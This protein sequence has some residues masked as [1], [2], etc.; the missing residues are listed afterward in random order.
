MILSRDEPLRI[1]NLIFHLMRLKQTATMS[2]QPSF[3]QIWIHLNWHWYILWIC[4]LSKSEHYT[5]LLTF[6]WWS[7]LVIL[8]F[9]KLLYL[10]FSDFLVSC[11]SCLEVLTKPW[12]WQGK[13]LE[14]WG[15]L[16]IV[17]RN[18]FIIFI[19]QSF[20]FD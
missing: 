17:I 5:P 4:S 10:I 12:W 9:E 1:V 13:E 7:L 11:I 20:Y 8:V 6:D 3:M 18:H 16:A 14:S 19:C 15:K 2:I